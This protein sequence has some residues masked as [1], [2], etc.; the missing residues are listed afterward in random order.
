MK[1]VNNSHPLKKS[2]FHLTEHRLENPRLDPALQNDK[3]FNN[4]TI[5]K[6]CDYMSVFN[7]PLSIKKY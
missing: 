5:I 4:R 6:I 7:I 1:F 3:Y 2:I